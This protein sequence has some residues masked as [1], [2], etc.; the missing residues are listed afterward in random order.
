MEAVFHRPDW[1][2]PRGDPRGHPAERRQGGRL[3]ADSRWTTSSA[4]D[5]FMTKDVYSGTFYFDRKAHRVLFDCIN[6]VDPT[7]GVLVGA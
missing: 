1:D 6:P 4:A 7:D 3:E 2:I 5:R